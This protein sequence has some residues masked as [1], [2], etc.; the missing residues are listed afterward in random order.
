MEV[1]A[2][3]VA[4][5]EAGE[6]TE[7]KMTVFEYFCLI[8]KLSG[9]GGNYGYSSGYGGSHGGSG[10]RVILTGGGSGG[11]GGGYRNYGGG[12]YKKFVDHFIV[13]TLKL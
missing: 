9:Y 6:I 10:I 3:R 5:M 4:V 11:H 13:F 2:I 12:N 7:V 8:F 1:G